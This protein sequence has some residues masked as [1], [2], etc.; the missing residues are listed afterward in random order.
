[1][2]KKNRYWKQDKSENI[3]VYMMIFDLVEVNKNI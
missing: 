3:N 1:M 2:K